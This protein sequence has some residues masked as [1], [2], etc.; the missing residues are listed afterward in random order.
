MEP[1]L[2]LEVLGTTVVSRNG[3]VLALRQRERDVLAGLAL[4]RDGPMSVT[5]LAEV[6][7]AGTPPATAAVT[8]Q[9]HVSR[10]RRGVGRSSI[11]TEVGGYQLGPGWIRDIDRRAA[12][13]AQA[14]SWRR[15]GRADLAIGALDE[16]I[17]LQRGVPFSDLG[18]SAAV[19]VERRRHAEIAR[20]I[21]DDLVVALLL[22]GAIGRAVIDAEVLAVA[23]PFREVRWAALAVALYRDGQRRE[24][25]RALRRGQEVLRSRVGLDVGPT[26][27]RLESLVFDDDPAL[28][29]AS[30]MQLLSRSDAGDGDATLGLVLPTSTEELIS[31]SDLARAAREA[32]DDDRFADA[33]ELWRLAADRSAQEEGA[34][35]V[36]TLH[37]RLDE[38]EAL[39]LAGDERRAAVVQ[40]AVEAASA[41]G[42]DV[43]GRAASAL[44]RLGPFTGPGPRN[45]EAAA[46]M[47]RAIGGVEDP[48]ILSECHGEA[49]L[50][51][52]LTGE[53]ELA[54]RHYEQS[55][56]IA[57]ATGD[58]RLLLDALSATYAIVTHPSDQ[59]RREALAAEMLAVAERS[60]DDDGRFTALHLYFAVQVIGAD[61]LVRTTFR[62]QEAL[63]RSLRTAARRWMVAYQRACLAYLDGRL[64]DALEIAEDAF[65]TAP[66][67]PARANSAYGMQL[68]LV[69]VAQGRGQ[70]LA[71]L[72]DAAIEEQ[73]ELPGWRAVAAWLAS[74]RGDRDRVARECQLLDDGRA[75]PP[76]M[77]WGGSAMILARAAAAVGL[78]G[79]LAT[80]TDLL[81]PFSGQFTWFGAGTVGPFDLALAEL[82]LAAGDRDL[83]QH[84]LAVARRAV[85][86]IGA[87]V[88]QP[89]LDAVRAALDAG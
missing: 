37:L 55:I 1:E 85:T 11:R 75:L 33:A 22:A 60:D 83:A 71:E 47:E 17:G 53:V 27:Q 25:V 35:A 69:R 40:A 50:F 58:P 81:R 46:L 36:A 86:A 39:E 19:T 76:D 59:R 30:P 78:T 26:L 72:V 9:N 10:L 31:A 61:P 57:R 24:A 3:E 51:A 12:A 63:A 20:S 16:A 87:V 80:F 13:V 5:D 7:W 29:S 54:D 28:L 79:S 23:E 48:A 73:P 70:E 43:L 82:A 77:T 56:A 62:H 66:V 34:D 52:S 65:A 41:V 32:I 88:F 49:A 8:L 89:D 44:C 4:V 21:E 42:G 15:V 38:A 6:V 74:M 68:L 18:A 84:H 14:A 45:E 2:G 67:A 64:D